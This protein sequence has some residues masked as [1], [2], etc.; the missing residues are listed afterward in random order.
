MDL[1]FEH[2]LDDIAIR[3]GIVTVRNI[4]INI[5]PDGFQTELEKEVQSVQDGLDPKRETF[6]QAG[7][8]MLRNG[9]YKPTGRSKPSSEYLLR[10]ATKD[11][12]PGINPIVDINNLISL[13]YMV[14]ISLWDL[15]RAPSSHVIF[16]LG[17]EGESFEFNSAGQHID[18]KDL[19]TG[20]AVDGD[21]QHPMINPVKD[22]LATKTADDTVNVGAAVYYPINAGSDGHLQ[23][24]LDE[25]GEWLS[26]VGSNA[27]TT[28]CIV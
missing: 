1:K 20:F 13:R 22:A 24:L 26:K 10:E 3:I 5:Y 2:Q 19:I 9:S 16:R 21:Q 28:S 8:E 27:T 7:R 14:P 17:E 4:D 11:N 18:L 25:F 12:F 15:D 23:K 6:R